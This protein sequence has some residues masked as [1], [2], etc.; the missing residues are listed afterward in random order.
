MGM[1]LI[2]ESLKKRVAKAWR[3]FQEVFSDDKGRLVMGIII[4]MFGAATPN[5]LVMGF[6]LGVIFAS[7]ISLCWRN[8]DERGGAR[9]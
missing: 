4:A 7:A 1:S 8:T 9:R 2:K 3:D 5:A 6:G